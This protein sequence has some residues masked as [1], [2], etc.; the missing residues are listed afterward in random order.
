MPGP[1]YDRTRANKWK[2]SVP[3]F[4]TPDAFL[5]PEILTF[6]PVRTAAVNTKNLIVLFD[7]DE[8][9]IKLIIG[10]AEIRKMNRAELKE[11]LMPEVFFV[12]SDPLA[13][14]IGA[15]MPE[16][17]DVFFLRRRVFGGRR[18]KQIVA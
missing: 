16:R 11:A 14:F 18:K 9:K 3:A 2:I 7:A 1:F 5:R 10:I 17:G 4:R 13:F 8:M 12:R 6:V 15:D